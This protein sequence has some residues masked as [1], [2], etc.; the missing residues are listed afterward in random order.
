[1]QLP[2]NLELHYIDEARAVAVQRGM[3]S[4]K[5]EHPVSGESSAMQGQ[6]RVDVKPMALS[7]FEGEVLLQRPQVNQ[8]TA[9]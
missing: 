8:F 5:T 6:D 1:M 7:M 9:D 4:D 3:A 2:D